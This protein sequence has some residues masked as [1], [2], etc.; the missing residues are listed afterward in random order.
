MKNCTVKR[1]PARWLAL[2][3]TLTGLAGTVYANNDTWSGS[4]TTP[5]WSDAGNWDVV[6]V[7]GDD[8]ILSGTAQTIISNDISGLSLGWMWLSSGSYNISG[9]PLTLTGG[10]TNSS[11][12]NIIVYNTT[13][14]GAQAIEADAGTLTFYGALTNTGTLT[15][16]GAGNV[17]W[18]NTAATNLIPSGLRGSGNFVVNGPGT[19]TINGGFIYPSASVNFAGNTIVNGGSLVMNAGDFDGNSQIGQSL[20]I[21]PGGSVTTTAPHIAG[22]GGRP[23]AIYGGSLTMNSGGEAYFTTVT[24][25]NATI[26]AGNT[27]VGGLRPNNDITN[28]ASAAETTFGT[29]LQLVSS[30]TIGVALGTVVPDIDFQGGI[31][32]GYNITKTGAGQMNISS[33]CTFNNLIINAGTVSLNGAGSLISPVISLTTNAVLDVTAMGFFQ[34][35]TNQTLTGLGHVLGTLNDSG[36]AYGQAVSPGGNNAA[37]TMMIDGLSLNGGLGLNFDIANTTGIG[38]GTNDLIICTN[39]LSLSGYATN[40]VAINFLNGTPAAGGTYTLIQYSNGPA[41]GPITTL[42]AVASRYSYNFFSDGS[43]IKVTVT[44]SPG[45]L[46][47]KGDG[48]TNN[49]DVNTS[50]N[51]LLSGSPSTYLAGDNASFT[52]AGSNNVPVQL[53]TTLTP[54]I[55]T[56][57]ST[58]NYTFGGAGYLSGGSSLYKSGSGNLT[59]LTANNNSGAS[60]LNGSG[61]INVGNGGTTGALGTGVMTNNS[62]VNFFISTSTTYAG[63]MSGTGSVTA[64]MPGSSTLT[65]T[66]TNTFT[67]GLTVSNGLVQFTN[68]PGG[69]ITGPI[70]NYAAVYYS[71]SDAFTNQSLITSAG[72]TREYGNGDIFIRGVGGM[73]ADG[74][75]A[76]SAGGNLNVGYSLLGSL[77]VN[78]GANITVANTMNLGDSSGIAGF[79]T[80]NGGNLNV[81]GYGTVKIL[82]IG[83]WGSEVSTY[84]MNGGTL[85]ATNAT[86]DVGS[87]GIGV[88][89]MSGG[90]VN[91]NG[92]SIDN[93]GATAAI[94]GT[95]ST[96]TMTGGQLNLGVN[97]ISG[98]S[99]TNALVPTVFLGNA[100]IA[101]TAPA[102]WSTVFNLRLTNGNPTIDTTNATVTLSGILSGSGG[103][104]KAGSGYLNLNATN[105][106]TNFTTV[107]AGTLQGSGITVSP[108]TVQAGANLSAGTTLAAGTLTASNVT[109]NAGANLVFDLS[110]T[111]TTSDLLYARGTLALNSTPVSFNFLGGTPYTNGAYTI[112]SNLPA[113]TGS[114]VYTNP[115]RYAV[116]LDQS[117]A[118]RVQVTFSGT[119]GNLYWRGTTSS[120]WNVAA[121]TNWLNGG[122]VADKYYQSDAVVFDNG[123]LAVT[124][125]NLA[126]AMT[127]ASVLVNSSGNYLFSGSPISGVTS[128]TKSGPG[129]LTLLNSNTFTGGTTVS[130]GTLQIG[131]GGSTGYLNGTINDNGSVVFNLASPVNFNGT[132]N[133]LGTLTQ[134][135]SG[136]LTITATQN[137]YGGTTINSGSTVQL[138]L[139]PLADAG[140]LGNGV[141]TNNGTVIFNRAN[142]IAVAAAYTGGG[143]LNFLGTGYGGTTAYSL[144][145]TNTFTGPVNLTYARI[146]SGYGAYSFGNPSGISVT[147]GS[148]VYAVATPYSSVYNIPLNLAGT[149]WADGLGALRIESGG[150]W[151]GNITLGAAARIG[152]NNASTNFVTGNISGNYELETYGG[153]AAAQLILAPASTNTYNALRVS[154]GTAGAATIAGNAAAIPN[155]IPLTMNGGVLKL[156]GY[157]KSFSSF[158]NLSASSIIENGSATSPVSVTLAQPAGFNGSYSGTFNDGGA[159]P[160]NV[161]LNQSGPGAAT[162]LTGTSTAWT[163]NFTNSGGIVSCA[164]ATSG[165]GSQGVVGRTLAGI[166]GATFLTTINN[167]LN[168]YSGSVVLSNSTWITTRYISWNASGSLYLAN[169]TLTGTNTTDGGPYYSWQFPATVTVRGSAP[170][171]MYGSGSGAGFDV[172]GI[173]TT[174]DVADATGNTNSDLI[175]TAPL[176]NSVNSG[177]NSLTKIGAGTLELDGANA[178]SGPT[179]INAGSLYLGSSASFASA[180]I[181]VASGATFDVSALGSGLTLNSGQTLG[182]NGTVAGLI[183]DN[184]G[185]FI[186]P[187]GNGTAGTLT[188]SNLNL[189]G[190]STINLDLA[191]T[192][193]AAANDLIQVSGNLNLSTAV[194][195]PIKFNFLNGAPSANPYTI[196][197][198][199][200]T[201]TGTAATAFTNA[202]VPSRYTATFNQ[203]G[204]AITV[205]FTGMASNLVWTGTDPLTPATWDVATST[206]WSNGATADVYYQQD[207]VR[208]DNTSVNTNVTLAGTVNPQ[209]VTVDSTNNYSIT[210]SGSGAIAGNTGLTK[211]NTNYLTVSAPNT[212]TGPV[213]VNGGKLLL[214]GNSPL[215]GGG[216]L[217]TVSN[218]AA[219][220]FNGDSMNSVATRA[221]SFTVGGSGPDGNGALINSGGAIYSYANVSNLTLTANTVLGGNNGR[222]DVGSGS[223][224]Q[225]VNGNGYNLIKAGS[226][227]MDFRPQFVTNL[228]SLVVSNGFL[229]SDGYSFTNAGTASI[230]VSVLPGASLGLSS[231]LIW[232]F[233]LTLTN[234]AVY[235]NSSAGSIDW[236][237]GIT[238]QGTNLFSI[239][240]GQVLSGVV[241]G[242]GAIAVGGLAGNLTTVNTLTFSNANTF[243][244]GI[245]LSNALSTGTNTSATPG[246]ATIIVTSSNGLGSGPLVF[247]LSLNATNTATNVLRAVEF[248]IQGGGT[249]ANTIVL[250]TAGVTNVSM[251]GH[252]ST[253]VFSLA[254]QISGGFA[255]LTNWIDF[256]DS[257]SAG[258]MRL[259]C[260][261]NTFQGTIYANR[262][263]VAIVADGSLGNATNTL[264]LNQ[265]SANG[266]L[267]FDATNINVAH[268]IIWNA[269]STISV[270]GDNDNDGIPEVGNNATI[271]GNMS[272]IATGAALN[273]G[274]GT[275]IAGTS[276][277]TLTLSG[278]NAVNS[279]ITVAANTKLIAAS[280]NALSA[281]AYVVIMSSGA[282]LSL[283]YGGTYV[284][285]PIQISGVGVFS[286]GVG[287]GALE[288]LAGNNTYGSG[289]ALNAASTIGLTAGNLTLGGAISGAFPLTITSTSPANTLTLNGT[290]TYNYATV[291]NGGTV[292]VNGSLAAGNVV[293]VNSGATL[294][295]TGTINGPVVT[296]SG[297]TFEPGTGA[298]IGKLTV[299]NTLDL[300]GASVFKIAKPSTTTNDTVVGISSVFYGGTLTVTNL[301]GTLTTGDTFKLF[302]AQD[303]EGSFST[304]TLPALGANLA[305]S[306]TLAIN[307][308]IQ[309]ITNPPTV[310]T[311]P[312][313]MV[314]SLSPDGTTLTLSWPT[315]HIGW[316]LLLQTNNLAS[317]IS[318]NSNDWG[319]VTGSSTT[320]LE[321]ITINPALP[322]EF[323][324]MVYP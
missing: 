281:S 204:N 140:S 258:V 14:S 116:N 319:T 242:P 291:I 180:N 215:G 323:Y 17:T 306:N 10:M 216:N 308:S 98:N 16:M 199:S 88:M 143:T 23:L 26:N 296:A 275:N 193:N 267:R 119:N 257:G 123:G 67:G 250:P 48:T 254:G 84:T 300:S 127:P 179:F 248:N 241:S 32:G 245:I 290:E 161:T 251:Q 324:Q 65:F 69:R 178:Y 133:G 305:W 31:T 170:S 38:G 108:I 80:Q 207:S 270:Y 263:V 60:S 27:G 55:V 45:N 58:K 51:W 183:Q 41:A 313:S 175:M 6:P 282:T 105:T 134:A 167:A 18:S 85:S 20:T 312:F 320:N 195:N 139:G 271:S 210:S 111:A 159:K 150:T 252:D 47:W 153:N 112:I 148:Q 40:T 279:Q 310:S 39:N 122:L 117:Q 106:F 211:N 265:A 185:S 219:M 7:T 25:S 209:S 151:A 46:V 260:P 321:N 42:A 44:G 194:P 221:Y 22:S 82:S 292:L 128:L 131:N 145:A 9:F 33:V 125:I 232:N 189:S 79:V 212:F 268:S 74:T 43:S 91:A 83:L 165:F 28:L 107:A 13:F 235:N 155:N 21:N 4:G 72:N 187:G 24:L 200:G 227:T 244:G 78:S 102:G 240:G 63:N 299:T 101:A 54:T 93:N 154:I 157:D 182:G 15:V 322:S 301:S 57:N 286:G 262:G 136:T 90:T 52:D 233:P 121:D 81:N 141:V 226:F 1:S 11:D 147:A 316:R 181:V 289:I 206:N 149:G 213:A 68:S 124:N 12:G 71:R 162:A 190:A 247:N 115:T 158:Y 217:V 146:Q 222:W 49:W 293:T 92:L 186:Q 218:G 70:T 237:G 249:L 3:I 284:G 223:A 171:Y 86:I 87:D 164:L 208:F 228:A 95:N 142:S 89:T 202:L 311:T 295:G 132:L 129:K 113:R 201:I 29:P 259:A 239:S 96:F 298:V 214:A 261:T 130:G 35:T 59:I 309:V 114:L 5:N 304:V 253:S 277:G 137:H 169:S 315:D 203:V 30:R 99:A 229:Y 120:N 317:G 225:M 109:L 266:G 246:N 220:D 173:G 297:S 274:G 243:A 50:T 174:F 287:V 236:L 62:K 294:G 76:I 197:Q 280:S 100:T 177:I 97:G 192:T 283:N 314:S 198:C 234:A 191:G 205:T 238:V 255:G 144:N 318:A 231:G 66:G 103:L 273:I 94:G 256:G 19:V 288:N 53:T 56:V 172:A 61:V 230:P 110:S 2:A 73:T 152:V 176:R 285:R 307:G 64:F 160:V 272:T 118:G 188:F 156:N 168:G 276:Y 37:G 224:G 302:S 135:G 163:G 166:N 196:I 278:S 184:G 77:I 138:G 34:L 104:T 303:Y 75:A 8:V 126:S 36:T 264:F 269:A